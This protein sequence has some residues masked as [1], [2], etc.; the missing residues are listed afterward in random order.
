MKLSRCHSRGFS[1][2]E[3]LV[4]IVII[5]ILTLVVISSYSTF[6]RTTR[7]KGGAQR[8]NSCLVAARAHAVSTNSWYRV[9]LQLDTNSFW[10]DEIEPD[11][12]ATP[13]PALPEPARRPKVTTPEQLPTGLKITDVVVAAQTPDGTIPA[14]FQYPPDR[15]IVIRFRPD[16]SSDY[17]AIHLLGDNTD[18]A[19]DQNYYTVL[20]YSATA[21]SRIIP[22]ARL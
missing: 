7:I 13:N 8:I 6:R 18:P 1:F 17:A 4:V 3:L 5:G 19:V 14:P 9:V 22:R 11:S 12:N 15:F 20:L 21:K 10:I 16:G 2:L